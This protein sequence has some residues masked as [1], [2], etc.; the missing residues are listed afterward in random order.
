MKWLEKTYR[1]LWLRL[2]RGA[3]CKWRPTVT[4]NMRQAGLVW[5]LF[6]DEKR[7]WF[8]WRE[9]CDFCG[10]NCGQCG[11]T[12][13]IGNVGFSMQRMVDKIHHRI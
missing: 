8:T 10:G 13:R 4:T 7:E 12:G 3:S 1:A 11:M 5:A 9:V 6:A 2:R